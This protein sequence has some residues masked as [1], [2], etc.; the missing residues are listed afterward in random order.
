M[1]PQINVLGEV[2]LGSYGHQEGNLALMGTRKDA[3]LLWAPG[4]VPGLL[5]A[6]GRVPGFQSNFFSVVH[7]C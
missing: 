6:S 4:R 7:I 2:C 5:W 1:E 3:G